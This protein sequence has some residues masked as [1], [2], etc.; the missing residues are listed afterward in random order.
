M[1]ET[2]LC[3]SGHCLIQVTGLKSLS[4]EGVPSSPSIPQKDAGLSL[5]PGSWADRH[6]CKTGGWRLGVSRGARGLAS[7]FLPQLRRA[8][9]GQGHRGCRA[10]VQTRAPPL[11]PPR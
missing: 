1:K 4:V 2:Y 6:S 8:A 10:W 5:A 9:A 7:Q 11:L 3:P